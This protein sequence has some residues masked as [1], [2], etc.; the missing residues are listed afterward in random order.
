MR[1]VGYV[2]LF[3]SE[4]KRHKYSVSLQSV[5]TDL[6][7]VRKTHCLSPDGASNGSCGVDEHL[8]DIDG[9]MM[10]VV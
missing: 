5:V 10:V 8:N 4:S 9:V 7:E 6:W 3:G 2:K 1:D